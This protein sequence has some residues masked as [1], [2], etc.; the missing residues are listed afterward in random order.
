[1]T[2]HDKPAVVPEDDNFHFDVLGDKWWMTETA[3]FS[4]CKPEIGL[5]GWI[6]NMFRPNIG[7][8]SGGCWIWEPGACQPWEVPYYSNLTAM[9]LDR[10]ADLR[11][12]TL[13]NGVSIKMLEPLKKYALS[14]ADP[15]GFEDRGLISLDLTFDAV[16]PPRPMAKNDGSF[17]K[18]THF[19]QFGHV[20]G[21]ICLHGEDIDIDCYA[22]RDRSWG[23]RPEHRPGQSAYVSGISDPS[24][25]F[26]VVTKWNDPDYAITNGFFTLDGTTANMVSGQRRVTRDAEGVVET[27]KVEGKDDLGRDLHAEGRRLS[28]IIIN[29]H[30]FIDSNGLIEWTINGVTG[31]GE[32]QDMWPVH[33]WSKHRGKGRMGKLA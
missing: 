5:G 12:V 28:G 2:V 22:I 3:W 8:V 18:L 30:S 29:R 27:I 21:R 19:D 32:D 7:T 31:H 20:K 1:M 10:T 33:N 4:F 14:F 9:P 15:M 6:Y 16:M 24:R 25:C 23:P 11:D 26:L 13:R 17:Q